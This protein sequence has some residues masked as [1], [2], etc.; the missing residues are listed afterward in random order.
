MLFDLTSLIGNENF[1]SK[2]IRIGNDIYITEQN[3][4]KTL[5]IE[6]AKQHKIDERVEFLKNNNP[7]EVDGGI[8]FLSGTV[9]R[10]GSVSTSLGIPLT[11]Q[12]REITL[13]KLKKRIP[14]YSIR[15]L[16]E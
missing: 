10:I 7:D 5:H 12:A 13:E 16:V 3:D 1:E 6:L 2:F 15:D 11:N 14:R 4:L 9:L 8:I